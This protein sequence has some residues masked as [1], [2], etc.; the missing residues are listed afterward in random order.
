M[1]TTDD[2][3]KLR[4][5][6][7][8]PFADV[9]AQTFSQHSN[10][11][12]YLAAG[13]YLTGILQSLYFEGQGGQ[14]ETICQRFFGAQQVSPEGPAL[15]NLLS[16]DKVLESPPN[17]AEMIASIRGFLGIP[18]LP[19]Q[20]MIAGRMLIPIIKSLVTLSGTGVDFQGEDSKTLI[21]LYVDTHN[22]LA[23]AR[24]P[25]AV[26]EEGP[27][28]AENKNDT[29]NSEREED[30]MK[31]DQEAALSNDTP[32]VFNTL[33][34]A[35]QAVYAAF[36]HL[37]GTDFTQGDVEAFTGLSLIAVK[38]ATRDLQKLGLIHRAHGTKYSETTLGD[39][40]PLLSE[41][42]ARGYAVPN[43]WAKGL[44]GELSW[45]EALFY[46]ALQELARRGD[47]DDH[48][49]VSGMSGPEIAAH[50][51]RGVHKGS[52]GTTSNTLNRLQSRELISIDRSEQ[53]HKITILL[54]FSED[55]VYEAVADA[56]LQSLNEVISVVREAE[57]PSN[58]L[59]P[60]VNYG[61]VAEA[62]GQAFAQAEV[63]GQGGGSSYHPIGGEN[64]NPE[65]AYARQQGLGYT[66]TYDKE[67]GRIASV[68]VHQLRQF[69]QGDVIISPAEDLPVRADEA[70]A[71]FKVTSYS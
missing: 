14:G 57:I 36:L 69:N 37:L 42:E 51:Y 8:E 5:F 12:Q 67:T 23:R 64:M 7:G 32:H 70:A 13:V 59:D 52:G 16:A 35:Q 31:K 61:A 63:V 47:D 18:R 1:L 4:Q 10:P 39:G 22:S 45:H 62:V 11:A 58:D 9:V 17:T 26:D 65:I 66:V 19:Q 30:D 53:P 55:D 68:A 28:L 6:Y 60:G 49:V 2:V 3:I 71:P 27:G 46:V 56:D 20:V 21:N 34:A 29:S 41:D 38:K 54:D 50:A 24:H 25:T 15:G 40:E 33:T 44:N 48:A 43:F